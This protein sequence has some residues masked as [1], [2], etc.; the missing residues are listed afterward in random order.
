[1]MMSCDDASAMGG[2]AARIEVFTG[3]RRRRPWSDDEKARIVAE[4]YAGDGIT[5]CDVARRNGICPSQL[6]TWRRQLRRPVETAEPLLFVPAIVEPEAAPA[7]LPA[8]R[9]QR[10]RLAR[11]GSSP[12]PIEVSMDGISVRIGRGA[13]ATLIAA[14]LDAL[15]GSR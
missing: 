1:M 10:R 4:S 3:T 14:V 9:Q 5:V 13:D 12:A 2:R 11:R 8:Q 15:K 6:F 7:P